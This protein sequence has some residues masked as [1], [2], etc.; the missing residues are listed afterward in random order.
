MLLCCG[1]NIPGDDLITFTQMLCTSKPLL[2]IIRFL[3]ALDV[4]ACQVKEPGSRK[5][6]VPGTMEEMAKIFDDLIMLPSPH[7][8]DIPPPS[9]SRNDENE[10]MDEKA[11]WKLEEFELVAGTFIAHLFLGTPRFPPD[12]PYTYSFFVWN[13]VGVGVY[14]A[15]LW[16]KSVPFLGV[17]LG[18]PCVGS[19]RMQSLYMCSSSL[20]MSVRY[21][22]LVCVPIYC[23]LLD[24]ML[25]M[26]KWL[27][28]F[29]LYCVP[30][31][32][33]KTGSNLSYWIKWVANEWKLLFFSSRSGKT[34]TSVF[35]Q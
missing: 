14:W 18:G 22:S 32:W 15:V 29:T 25:H 17:E 12:F 19:I 30:D 35:V 13:S 27:M 28:D 11:L 24:Y 3:R 1:Q 5:H 34:L 31:I 7:Y 33:T 10:M 26:R 20:Y 2:M 21:H 16:D 23:L 4:E 6:L 9:A 8:Y